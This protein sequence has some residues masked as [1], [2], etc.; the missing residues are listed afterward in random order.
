MEAKLQIEQRREKSYW[1]M[2]FAGHQRCRRGAF[3]SQPLDASSSFF[4]TA[5]GF[6]GLIRRLC[7]RCTVFRVS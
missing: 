4:V 5:Y 3:V 6:I 1:S 7:T 2:S